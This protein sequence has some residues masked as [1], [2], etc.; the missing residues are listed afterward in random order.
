[1]LPFK[2]STTCLG[3]IVQCKWNR[4]DCLPFCLSFVPDPIGKHIEWNRFIRTL[5]LAN[6]VH[7]LFINRYNS[8]SYSHST[9][10]HPNSSPS[11]S[12]QVCAFVCPEKWVT[13]KY[14]GVKP[15]NEPSTNLYNSLQRMMWLNGVEC[16]CTEQHTT[17]LWYLFVCCMIHWAEWYMWP[18]GNVTN[19][20][21]P[22][23]NAISACPSDTW[24]STTTLPSILRQN[25]IQSLSNCHFYE[26]GNRFKEMQSVAVLSY[27]ITIIIIQNSRLWLLH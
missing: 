4:T 24:V 27:P 11:I 6:V 7:F 8:Q 23:D 21:W 13:H 20:T 18:D 9:Q 3:Y 19:F 2:S 15:S 1:M 17:R 16:S 10:I 22:D 26:N 5:S 12:T 14:L 25:Y